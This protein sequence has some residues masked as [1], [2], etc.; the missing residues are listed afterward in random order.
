MSGVLPGGGGRQHGGHQCVEALLGEAAGE[1]AV[2]TQQLPGV[3]V[4]R[5]HQQVQELLLRS[6]VEVGQGGCEHLGHPGAM[7]RLAPVRHLPDLLVGALLGEHHQ[8]QVATLLVVVD[9][10]LERARYVAGRCSSLLGDLVLG[11][12]HRLV[13]EAGPAAEVTQD[14]LDAHLGLRRHRVEPDL[15]GQALALQ[16]E[17]R[18]QDAPP[19]SLGGPRPGGHGVAASGVHW[20]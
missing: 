2:A 11:E 8:G 17:R 15:R 5:D 4:G 13:E 10:H 7:Q 18:L 16:V 1:T 6:R 9:E 12:E 3:D 14:R 19:G 20:Q